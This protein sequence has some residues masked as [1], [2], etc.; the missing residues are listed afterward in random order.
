MGLGWFLRNLGEDVVIFHG[1]ATGGFQSEFVFQPKTQ[2]GY[3]ML[4]NVYASVNCLKAVVFSLPCE[5]KPE[6]KHSRNEI[7]E[8]KGTYEIAPDHF[9][10]VTEVNGILSAQITGQDKV[11]LTGL[12]QDTFDV[13]QGL[14]TNVFIRNSLGKVDRL[15]LLQN[16]REHSFKKIK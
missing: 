14:A 1:G 12:K 10:F 11:R 3:V 6:F 9:Y 5:V 2:T 15:M 8:F 7:E 13:A 16:G 4:S